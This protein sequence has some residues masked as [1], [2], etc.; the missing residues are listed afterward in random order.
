LS[1]RPS[2]VACSA[3]TLMTSR[4]AAVSAGS[5]GQ[6]SDP[7]PHTSRFC[8]SDIA[9]IAS[10]RRWSAVRGSSRQTVAAI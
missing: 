7:Q 1:D 8:P 10:A 2:T 4:V 9:A 6:S 3:I 5:A